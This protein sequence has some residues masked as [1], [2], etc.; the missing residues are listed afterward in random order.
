MQ[1]T[2]KKVRGGGGAPPPRGL[3]CATSVAFHSSGL[4]GPTSQF[5]A[6]THEFSEL[7]LARMVLLL[8]Q[9]RSVLPLRSAKARDQVLGSCGGKNVRAHIGP[10]HII[11][12]EPVLFGRPERTRAKPTKF[13]KR[14]WPGFLET[15][16]RI[17]AAF[18][19][20]PT[21]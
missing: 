18:N 21:D 10:F 19:N 5:L 3:L 6:E 8:D 17:S 15:L 16:Y 20:G 9:S 13:R 7:V 4:S 11:W 14:N 2:K 1:D 12:P